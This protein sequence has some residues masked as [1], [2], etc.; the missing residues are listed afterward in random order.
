MYAESDTRFFLKRTPWRF[1]FTK[2]DAGEV[3]GVSADLEGTERTG[4]KVS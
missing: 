3:V 2:D 1:T 4:R